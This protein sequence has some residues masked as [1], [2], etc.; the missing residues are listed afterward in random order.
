MADTGRALAAHHL[1]RGT[2]GAPYS[3][4]LRRH[5]VVLRSVRLY[6]AL[7]IGMPPGVGVMLDRS[8]VLAVDPPA[9]RYGLA[10]AMAGLLGA[11][12][13]SG[14]ARAHVREALLG[15]GALTLAWL[16]ALLALNDLAA[17]LGP[18]YFTAVVTGSALLSIA[19]RGMAAPVLFLTAALG[20]AAAAALWSEAPAID[21]GLFL[22]CLVATSAVLLVTAAI[23]ERL[24]RSVERGQQLYAE[25]EAAGAIG[26]WEVYLASGRA[27]WSDGLCALLGLPPL[28][29]APAPALDAFV[30]PDDLAAAHAAFAAVAGGDLDEHS[31]TARVTAV[32]GRE[33]TLRGV[34]RAERD[35]DGRVERV[36]GVGVDVTAQLAH[37]AE[38]VEALD[39]AEAAARLKEA[40]LAN[41]SHEIRTP[42][43]AVIGYAEMLA[44]EADAETMPLVVPIV[45]GGQ[46]LL[47]TLNSVLDL[48]RLEAEGAA[49]ATRPV[50]LGAAAEAARASLAETAAAAGL[51]LG[52]E[53]PGAVWAAADAGALGRVLDNLV[54]NA[55]RFT[56]AG[57]VTLRVGAEGERVYVEVQDTGRGMDAAFAARATEPFVQESAGDARSH[58]GSGLGL[59]IVSRLVEAMGGEL[60]I[61]TAPGAGT[62]VRVALPGAA[63]EAL[64]A[65][66]PDEPAWVARR[67]LATVAAPA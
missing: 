49:L 23:R 10:L 50:D 4:H 59:S 52:V 27:R 60:G 13:A 24:M 15:L 19:F 3:A 25:A 48:A 5:D 38:L 29:G 55:I 66:P 45:C 54:S 63:S 2:P 32:D 31:V 11:T 51:A 42:L 47:D 36:V 44:D 41:M 40:I 37:Q 57:S 21:P 65:A 7:G 26:S 62:T 53:A 1:V 18:I 9:L 12:F 56:A 34:V 22:V 58:E 33:R 39:R 17:V 61:T 43:T 30:H 67:R 6:L 20:V 64:A 28:G 8:G 35:A 16:G 14:R 46:R